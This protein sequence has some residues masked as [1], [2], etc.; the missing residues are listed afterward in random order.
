M[1]PI[2]FARMTFLPSWSHL[3][4][5]TLLIMQPSHEVHLGPT[6]LSLRPTTL[7]QPKTRAFI[8]QHL[9]SNGWHLLKYSLFCPYAPR[10]PEREWSQ[11]SYPPGPQILGWKEEWL[12]S[13]GES[14]TV[15]L[16]Y[17]RIAPDNQD[18]ALL[19]AN[20]SFHETASQIHNWVLSY[21]KLHPEE[22]QAIGDTGR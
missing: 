10:D 18:L 8:E 2:P 3:D 13:K 20:L 6:A 16:E 17:S 14:I 22:L 5:E 9:T 4:L 19:W 15:I 1:S 12:N 21:K 7:I 11:Y